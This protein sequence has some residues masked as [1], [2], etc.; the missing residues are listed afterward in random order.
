MAGNG[1][2][3]HL[4]YFVPI[5]GPRHT[6]HSRRSETS[7]ID[8]VNRLVWGQ[9]RTCLVGGNRHTIEIDVILVFLPWPVAEE[10]IGERFALASEPRHLV[11]GVT[12]GEYHNIKSFTAGWRLMYRLDF[13]GLC[14]HKSGE[15]RK[16]NQG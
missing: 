5:R 8:I 13:V 4:I 12:L 15:C 16:E 9:T 14:Y 3:E 7:A 1:G 6:V 10:R 11:G 2:V